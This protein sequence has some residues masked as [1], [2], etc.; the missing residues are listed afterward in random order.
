MNKHPTLVYLESHLKNNIIFL[1]GA[2]GTM[3]QTYK[4]TEADFRKNFFENHPSDLKGNND[5]LVL[6]RPEVIKEIH[7]QYLEAGADI[8]ETNTFSANRLAQKD[9]DLEKYAYT[10]NVEAAKI[11]KS[12]CLE[13]MQKYPHR[14]CFVAGAIGPTNKTASLSPDVNNP[15]FRA[16]NFD[17][18]VS[19]YYEQIEGLIEGGADILLP[20][21]TF[22]T[23]NLKAC[24]FAIIKFQEKINCK[25]PVMLSV[26]ITDA[27]G[28]TLSGQTVEAFWNS[29]KHIEPLS[30][31]INCALGAK[32]MRP[33][34]EELSKISDCYISCYP[35][36]GLPN[37]LTPTGYDETPIMTAKYLNEFAV[38]GLVNI[39]G[40][41]CGT[42]P[43]HIKAIHDKIKNLSPRKIQIKN[44]GMQLSGLEPLNI[45]N[46][47]NK[48]F[49]MVGERTN[50]TG[51]PLFSKL[52][53]ENNFEKAVEVARNQVEN[54]ANII[55]IN[56]D[57]GL[58]NSKECMTRFLNLIAAEPDIA[59]V[60]IMIDSSKW[61]VLEAGLKCIQGKGIVNSISLKEGEQKFIEQAKLI[62]QYGAA[63]V[64]MAFD[65]NGQA[66]SIENK[67]SICKRAYDI[68]VNQVQF[69]PMD[70][71]FD[72]NIL[73]IATGIDEHNEF[74][75]NFIEAVKK[76]KIVCPGAITSG[77]VSN[78]SFS[79]R[80]NNRVREALHAVFLF[81]AIH[82]GLDM[83]IVNAGMLE[84]YDEIEPEL[85][86]KCEAVVLNLHSNATEELILLAEKLKS[87]T[88]PGKK[89][90][91][92]DEWRNNNYSEKI[93]HALVK[94]LD[95]FI[96]IDTEE[97][98][99]DLKTPLAVIEGPLM[100][101]M[102]IVGKLFG[103]GKMFLPQ[104]VKSARVMKKAVH[105]LEPFMPLNKT[106]TDS[107]KTVIMATVKGDVHDIGKNIVGIVL[108]CNGY[109][110]IDLG[111][112]VP[113]QKILDAAIKHNACLI[114]LSGLIT[115]SL[116]EMIYNATEMQ[117][118]GFTLPLLIGGAT[119]SRAHTAIKI[120]QHYDGPIVH[121]SDASLVTEV[122]NELL[123]P[124]NKFDFIKKTKEKYKT[125]RDDFNSMKSNSNEFVTLEDARNKKLNTNWNQ[126]EIATPTQ[127]GVIKFD[128][129]IE[130]L[131]PF[132]DWSPFFWT[133]EL[134]AS[135]PKIFNHPTYGEE[136]KKI[137]DEVQL[138]L[139]KITNE[140]LAKPKGL[141]GIFKA[142]SLP[143]DDVVI[144][145][146]GSQT[147]FNFLRQQKK[148]ESDQYLCVSDY[149]APEDSNLI[150]YMGLFSVTAGIE[151][152]EFANDYK[153]KNDDF[154]SILV[155]SLA[156]RLA[157][158]SAE[159]IH[160]KYRD[161]FQYGLRENLTPEDYQ[162]E[163][164]QGIRPAPGYP[165][166]P[167]HTEKEKIW[168]TLNV[169][170]N[171]GTI[172]TENYAMSPAS[173]VCGY[174]LSH[175]KSKYYNVG[176]IQKDQ[177]LS[178]AH[179]KNMSVKEVE[180]W[181]G[182]IVI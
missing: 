165:S 2:M 52:I 108:S 67:I 146:N 124:T 16:V 27:S 116:D 15:G 182:S 44:F 71:I 101:G 179:R 90:I 9:Y 147:T 154:N 38:S 156:D 48:P 120:D 126:D 95:A 54:G 8:I 110:V 87:L 119:T 41:C 133:W 171:I 19:V 114:G 4:L 115:P 174:L 84:V 42:T 1:D 98:R 96:E 66:T 161:I 33:Y 104:V 18:L 148:N 89:E 43:D 6:T 94:G 70:I 178:Y 3:I 162:N 32:E 17:D 29:V 81:H 164:Y 61:E 100:E 111:V 158:A 85:K 168:K 20:E 59:R 88:E 21:T 28:R 73:T 135:Y 103:E 79:F 92:S 139:K 31:G 91:Q 129:T 138:M 172:L 166:T 75:V 22:D 25:L 153:R 30:V 181:L 155:M 11:A 58:L 145:F 157:E 137:F 113:N 60:P 40:G 136:A 65:E 37:P 150:D 72:C 170:Q 132:I 55:D 14:K 53:K 35:N 177:I 12:A 57:E 39:I 62:K 80:G 118:Q 109:N 49:L 51:S 13:I 159:L 143:T 128:F 105:Y 107:Q 167:D 106:N 69:N 152:E 36:A 23:L 45:I 122:C 93:K 77:G 86:E 68:L 47:D 173:S 180:K 97:A 163:K 10:I 130:E 142:K 112:M 64:V 26:T 24:I 99:L 140:K 82:A 117:R 131:I 34:I 134:K 123:S 144:D 83:G 175:P 169:T 46:S 78:L 76:I 121:V 125:I 50:V 149:I 7:L 151:I 74:A 160:K 63:V 5:L 127:T 102:K 141:L 56:F 176:T